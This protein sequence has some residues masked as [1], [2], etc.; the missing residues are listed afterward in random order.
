[1]DEKTVDSLL[2]TING[3]VQSVSAK[4]DSLSE[5]LLRHEARIT[6]LE[7]DSLA[8]KGNS[9]KGVGFMQTLVQM[10]TKCVII[11]VTA[12]CCV[13]GGSSIVSKMF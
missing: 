5:T 6:M 10:L 7:K 1:M 9:E 11:A 2:F 12:L 8:M 13:A 3:E 4:I